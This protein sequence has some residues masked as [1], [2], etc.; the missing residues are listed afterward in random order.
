MV[1]KLFV[2]NFNELTVYIQGENIMM[3]FTDDATL[4]SIFLIPILVT[5]IALMFIYV[6]NVIKSGY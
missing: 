5:L 1:L 2:G 3:M 6:F 4:K